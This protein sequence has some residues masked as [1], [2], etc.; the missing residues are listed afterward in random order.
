MLPQMLRFL[1]V[2]IVLIIPVL[3]A[4]SNGPDREEVAKLKFQSIPQLPG[5]ELVAMISGISG[6]SS[7][8]CYGGYV[9]ALY[10]TNLSQTEIVDFYRQYAHDNQWTDQ[11]SR[12]LKFAAV[13]QEG[14]Y[15]LG[16]MMIAPRS[17]STDLYPSLIDPKEIDKSLSEFN[18]VYVVTVS[19]YPGRRNC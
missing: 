17:S 10:G 15:Y 4:C 13:Q 16:V 5:S 7:E 19:Y 3:V 12:E 6:G 9:E 11:I 8:T 1:G 18:V 2:L 14:D